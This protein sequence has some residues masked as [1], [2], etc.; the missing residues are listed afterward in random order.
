MPVCAV[1][2]LPKISAHLFDTRVVNLT[3]QLQAIDGL[4]SDLLENL[5]R[6]GVLL[7]VCHNDVLLEVFVGRLATTIPALERE[8]YSRYPT[9]MSCETPAIP[10]TASAGHLSLPVVRDGCFF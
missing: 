9:K 1:Q 6:C 10:T 4:R 7:D 3:A 5:F 2:L 8:S